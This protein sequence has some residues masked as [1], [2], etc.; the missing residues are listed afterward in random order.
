MLIILLIYFLYRI[1]IENFYIEL[2]LRNSKWLM[3]C[4]YSSHKNSIG[5]HLNRLGESLDAFSPN[6]EN[7]IIFED[8]NVEIDEDHMKSF[9]ESYGL[10]NLIK[11]STCYKNPTNP[12]CMDLFLTSVAQYFQNT[13]VLETGLPVF[14][15]MAM[16]CHVKEF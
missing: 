8:F 7:I 3:N 5:T 2:N 15:L 11:Q 1:Y 12:T 6:Y 4:S 13:R 16:D 14:Y 9:C 10:T